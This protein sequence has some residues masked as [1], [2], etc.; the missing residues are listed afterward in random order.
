M[1][2]ETYAA[3][4]QGDNTQNTAYAAAMTVLAETLPLVA[5]SL[6][7]RAWSLREADE[8]VALA[9]SRELEIPETLA[10]L[11]AGRGVTPEE[12]PAYLSPS[13]RA[14]LP[15]PSHFMDMEVA[16]ERIAGAICASET[17]AVFGDYDVDGAT[18]TA[19]LCRFFES[20][21]LRPL[22]YIPDRLKEGYGP[23][24]AALMQL[25]SRGASVIIT[26]DCGTLAYAPLEAAREA[27]LDVIVIDHHLGE[28]RRPK[29]FAVVNPNRAD[30][31]V[32]HRQL[33]AVGV[34]FLLAVA[35]NRHLRR[36]GW[37]EARP[38]PD[39]L[40]LLDVVALGTIC[41][42]V[43]LTGVNRALVAQGLKILA[44]RSN[45]GLRTLMD[46]SRIDERPGCYHAGFILGP[47]INAGGRVGKSD[48]GARLL[49]TADEA[50]ALTLAR[51]LDQYNEERKAIEAL[52]LEQALAQAEAQ[53]AHSPL[54]LVAAE[55][56]HPGVIGIVAGR[57]K[58]RF[59]KPAAV[60]ALEG[61]IGKASAR[62]VPG[63]DFG[64]SVH[65]ACEANLLVAGG[66]H[67]MAA[68]FTVEKEKLDALHAF[69][70]RRYALAGL[71]A[72]AGRLKLDGC[73][74]LSGITPELAHMLERAG[75]YGS[76][77]PQPRFALRH[78]TI[79]AVDT[80]KNGH[81]R[82]IVT[83]ETRKRLPV[84]AFRSQGTPYGDA[85]LASRGRAMHLAGSLKLSTWQGV[86]QAS[87][88]LED[89]ALV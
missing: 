64:A 21:A 24:T 27:G 67:A 60:V 68:G 63:F 37:F 13:L 85:L 55:G 18:S 61:G 11:L 44:T 1:T 81:I 88:T 78:V 20:L 38:E 48:Y 66:G 34:A 25:K 86:E 75:P 42:V 51:A 15:D 23:N 62:S 46:V 71:D 87:F 2:L 72:G 33:A 14:H 58:E 54:I 82:L 59:G 50:E 22:T 30:E 84:L 40:A 16:A 9:M 80:L 69:L 74:A 32:A 39:L 57:I 36:C 83:D 10:R 70:T 65:A 6:S 17:V 28:A 3:H 35:V 52:V 8:R 5:R 26:V 79:A 12:A 19:L 53:N 45:L 4:P 89:A 41:D 7:G 47:R 77:N 49:A 56:W 31:T 73:L 76:G 43:P 29:A